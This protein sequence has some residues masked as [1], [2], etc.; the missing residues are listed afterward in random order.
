VKKMAKAHKEEMSKSVRELVNLGRLM[1]AL[2]EYKKCKISL[3]KA[4]E[5]AG[6]SISEM[7]TL[8]SEFS[9]PNNIT[10]EDYLEGL[11]TLKKMWR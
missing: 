8:L 11:Q 7:M 4:A 5:I 9:I 3:G 6:V 2:E 10:Y 1:F